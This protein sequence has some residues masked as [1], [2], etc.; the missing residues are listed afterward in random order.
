MTPHR[1]VVVMLMGF[2]AQFVAWGG[3]GKEAAAQSEGCPPGCVSAIDAAAVPGCRYE[4]TVRRPKPPLPGAAIFDE[5]DGIEAGGS[6]VVLTNAQGAMSCV[7]GPKQE[8]L[9]LTPPE[10]GACL[11]LLHQAVADAP[12]DP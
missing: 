9:P 7:R 8:P 4:H 5:V 11:G 6:V 3:G 1:I 12:C 10:Y 2:L